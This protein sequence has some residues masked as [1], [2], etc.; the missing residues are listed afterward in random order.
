MKNFN[1]TFIALILFII[2]IPIITITI[3]NIGLLVFLTFILLVGILLDI[4][5]SKRKLYFNLGLFL[6]LVTFFLFSF[7]ALENSSG[8]VSGEQFRILLLV[9]VFNLIKIRDK[10][11][12]KLQ[13]F[14]LFYMTLVALFSFFSSFRDS[15]FRLYINFYGVLQDPNYFTMYY[16]LAF[17]ICI[18]LLNFSKVNKP[19]LLLSLAINL[20]FILSSG[21]R[22]T[23]LSIII[24]FFLLFLNNNPI[25]RRSKFI[26]FIIIILFF[27]VASFIP[28]E[29]LNRFSI[30]RLID[31]GGAGRLDIWIFYYNELLKNNFSSN[32]FGNG[33]GTLYLNNYVPHNQIL[34]LLYENGIIG[35]IVFYLYFL[36]NLYRSRHDHIFYFNISIFISTLFLT[37]TTN[38]YYW[39]SFLLANILVRKNSLIKHNENYYN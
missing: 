24:G 17:F 37:V 27:I 13:L 19:I 14:F 21:S 20:F 6:Y 7:F 23:I 9:M 34:T 4:F 26:P 12:I 16:I 33:L 22:G 39:I 8:N 25:K 32:L 5:L 30:F 18:Q 36:D 1:F 2:G 38:R 11:S 35:L 28:Q 10:D 29:L 15:E 3:Y 31:T